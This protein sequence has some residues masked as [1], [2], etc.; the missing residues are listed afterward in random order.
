VCSSDLNKTWRDI[1]WGNGRFVALASDGTCSYSLDGI[2]W[3]TAVTIAGGI[4]TNRIAYGQGVFVATTTTTAL[5]HSED[6][7]VW[8]AITS[9]PNTGYTAVAFG[10]PARTGKFVLIGSGTTTATLDARIG[11]RARGRA[12][13]SNEQIF[14]VRL[15]EPGS[16]YTSAPTI[17]VTDPNNIFD[18]VLVPRLGSGTLAN[19]TF[20]NRGTGYITASAEIDAQN[21]NGRADFIQDG[22][23]IAVKRLSQRPVPGSNVE[24]NSLPGQF[25]KL[26]NTISFLGTNPGSF[27]G[28]LQVSPPVDVGT[29]LNNGEAVELRIRFSQVR[30]TGH[31]FLDIGTGG[32]DTTNYPNTPLQQ[33]VQANETVENN[34]G[35][36]FYTATD[37]D[38]NFRVGGLFS[39]EQSTGVATLNADAF[40]IAGL[41]EL[42][43]G[44]VTLGG[45]SATVTEFSTDPFF[46]A[47][48]DNIVPTQRAVKAYIEAQIGGGG[49]SLNVNSV[50][51]GDIFIGANTITT[52]SGSPINIKANV[53][54]SGTVLGLPLA[55]NYFLR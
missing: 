34:G 25:F 4:T 50:T 10:N 47:N 46:T 31:D 27:T 54:F 38:G 2:E 11:A 35:R 28:F 37:Q 55:Y 3:S 18:V 32:F 20:V 1:V 19:P 29:V 21:S 17:T 7:I 44:E 45:N 39:I 16:G 30:L 52:V 24:F 23:F 12:G 6:G 48:S 33:P 43:L 40:N 14:E 42:S 9:L 22:T 53:V 41:Q 13:V 49:A 15:S 26:V 36:V 5:Y 8:T 51:A